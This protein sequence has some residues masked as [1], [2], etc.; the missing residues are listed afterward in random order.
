MKLQGASVAVQGFGNV[1]STAARL[2]AE[3]GMKVV[4]VSDKSGGIYNPKGLDIADCLKWVNEHRFLHGYRKAEAV[5]NDELLTLQCDV[6]VPAALENVITSKNAE[7]HPGED[8]LRRGERAD[9]RA[10]GCHPRR[11]GRVCHSRTS[12]P[13]PAA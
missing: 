6:L 13:T 3:A 10:S 4:A 8:H 11:E 1:G 2:M 12:W 5:S 7:R 9:H